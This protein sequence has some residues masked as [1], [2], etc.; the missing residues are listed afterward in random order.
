MDASRTLPE[1]GVEAEQLAERRAGQ[2]L[3]GMR[4]P[5]LERWAGSL[6]S[7]QDNPTQ[8]DRVITWRR[9]SRPSDLPARTAFQ[10]YE[11]LVLDVEAIRPATELPSYDVVVSLSNGSR[12]PL[13][14]RTWIEV[15]ARS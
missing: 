2:A 12:V 14:A 7:R 13:A 11:R 5:P 1:G 15:E 9:R 6:V 8:P 3:S 10:R 4:V